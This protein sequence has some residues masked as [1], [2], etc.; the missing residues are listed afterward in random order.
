MILEIA[1]YAGQVHCDW[2]GESL[3]KSC[4]TDARMLQDAY[5]AYNA[6]GDNH[7]L[8]DLYCLASCTRTRGKLSQSAHSLLFSESDSDTH[9]DSYESD[10]RGRDVFRNE[11]S[12]KIA[13][14]SMEVWSLESWIVVS[15]A[16]IR[17]SHR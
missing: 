4:G 13:D 3:E 12:N 7:F 1:S 8:I 5:G 15:L 14:K 6:G 2:D 16:G 10:G 9:F 17:S 11:L